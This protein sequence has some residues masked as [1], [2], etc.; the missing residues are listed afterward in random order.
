[1]SS[2]SWFLSS[3]CPTLTSLFCLKL[4]LISF[5]SVSIFS[6]TYSRSGDASIELTWICMFG[7]PYD[8]GSDKMA[9]CSTDC[10][11]SI[12]LYFEMYSFANEGTFVIFSIDCFSSGDICIDSLINSPVGLGLLI[13]A[14]SRKKVWPVWFWA[15]ISRFASFSISRLS[16]RWLLPALTHA[17]RVI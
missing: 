8:L 6:Y 5:E 4:S 14:S 10:T 2:Y 12:V 15:P 16:T 3:V 9:L 13:A 1:M 7:F 17:K 11:Y